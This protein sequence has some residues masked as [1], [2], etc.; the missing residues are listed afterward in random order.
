MAYRV[1]LADRAGRDLSDLYIHIHAT[2]SAAAAKWFNGLEAAVYALNALPQ[3]CPIAPEGKKAKKQLRH[4]LYG[5]K[6]RIYRA[7][8]EID[9]RNKVVHVLTIRHGAMEEAKPD[10]LV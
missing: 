2:E 3:R 6:P 9:E 5:N 8:F 7:I 10:E 1:E 4:L